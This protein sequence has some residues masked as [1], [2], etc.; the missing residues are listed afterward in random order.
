[1]GVFYDTNVP[2]VPVSSSDLTAET[3]RQ[4]TR[5]QKSE[6]QLASLNLVYTWLKNVDWEGTISHR[7]LQTYNDQL[8]EFNTQSH[9]P[10][11]GVLYRSNMSNMPTITGLQHSYDFITLG[12]HRFTQRHIV[13]PYFTLVEDSSNLTTLQFRFQ[14]KDFFHDK[15]VIQGP[16]VGKSDVRDALNY[17][18]GPLPFFLFEE[19]RHFIKLGYRFDCEDA[20]GKNWTY[21]GNRL[22]FGFQYTL[23]WWDIKLRHDLDFHWRSH[24][25]KNTKLPTNATDTVYRSDREPINLISLSKDFYEDFT[26]SLEYL[27]DKNKSNLGAFEYNRHVVTTSLT[28]RFD[29]STFGF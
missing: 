17:M 8:T 9:T 24:Q 2:V 6:G 26:V 7:F 12:N 11:L 3:I 22:L 29:A 5:R 14:A 10:T 16:P 19:G 28:Y 20:D 1:M 21:R 13:N 18:V 27:F 25:S 4:N 15:K 23:P